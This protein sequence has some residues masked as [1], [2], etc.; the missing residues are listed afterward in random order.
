MT[1]I[2]TRIRGALDADDEAFLAALDPE[3]WIAATSTWCPASG[4]APV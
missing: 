3:A 1:D 4:C 2:D